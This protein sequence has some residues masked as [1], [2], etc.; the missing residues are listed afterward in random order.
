MANKFKNSDSDEIMAEI[1]VTPLID[2]MLVLLI[3]FMV[4]SSLGLDSGLDI[5]LPE[6]T[7]KTQ[8]KEEKTLLISLDRNGALSINGKNIQKEGLENYL[9]SILKENPNQFIVL[10]GDTSSSLGKTVEIMDIARKAGAKKFA[11]AAQEKK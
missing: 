6:T 2:I 9:Q 1:N 7:S 5:E 3:I 10:Q 4:T 11:I 8:K